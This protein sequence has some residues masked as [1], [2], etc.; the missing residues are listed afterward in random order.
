MIEPSSAVLIAGDGHPLLARRV[1]KVAGLALVPRTIERF[2]DGET[3]VRI[4]GDVEGREVFLVQ[5]TSAPVNDRLMALALLAEAARGAGAARLTAVLPYFGYARQDL[6]K[7]PGEARSAQLAARILE[8]AGFDRIVVLEPHS[9]GLENAF[10]I[11]YTALDADNAVLPLVRKW[12]LR[13]LTVV[14]PD[15]GGVKR[16]QR[17]AAALA[18]PLAVVAKTRPRADAAVAHSLLGEVRG[19]QCLIVDDMASTGGT[20]ATAAQALR[21]AGAAAVHA[22]FVHAVMA[23]GAFE[24]IKKAGVRL[25]GTT[26]SVPREGK[27]PRG[28]KI[29]GVASLLARSLSE[30]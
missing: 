28:L 26:N 29:V 5:P 16:A 18:A 23:P 10:R 7:R 4:E 3:R 11:P 20:I 15:A 9:Q 27:T 12:R 21:G 30:P 22:F 14:S 25:I 17:Y 8:S 24:R 13:D 2:A 19:R 6:R 1:A